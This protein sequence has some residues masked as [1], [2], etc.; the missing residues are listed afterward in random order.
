[1][2][3]SQAVIER[4]KVCLSHFVCYNA[5]LTHWVC[6]VCA[7]AGLVFVPLSQQPLSCHGLSYITSVILP[8]AGLVFV[9]LSQPYLHEYGDDWMSNSRSHVM[10][11]VI[12]HL[13]FCLLQGWCLCR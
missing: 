4:V 13:S 7:P 9:P 1:V 5:H 10:S 11:Y 6:I 3:L 12:L 8:A 2:S